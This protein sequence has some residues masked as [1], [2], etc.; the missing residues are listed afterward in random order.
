[1]PESVV[2][3]EKTDA[4]ETP[5]QVPQETSQLNANYARVTGPTASLH[6]T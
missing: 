3:A 5:D 4:A 1:M 2:G 6:V